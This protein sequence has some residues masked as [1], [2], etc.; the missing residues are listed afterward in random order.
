[1]KK[2][3]AFPFHPRFP[4]PFA[5]VSGCLVLLGASMPAHA[6]YKV[7]L[8]APKSLRELLSAHL[9]LM[10]YRDRDDINADQLRF[11]VETGAEQV[12]EL[13]AT[14]GYFSPTADIR[15]DTQ[16]QP[17]VVSVTVAEGPRT[18]IARAD[19][20]VSGPAREQSPQQA[21][22]VVD[23]WAMKPGAPFRQEDWAAAKD[24]GLRV[25]QER[26]YA[27]AAIASS[28]A[29]IFA[30]RNEAELAVN[31][32]SG[33]PF[34]LGELRI[35]G[36]S[37]YPESII[38][39]VNPLK[40]GEDYDA[41]RLLALQRAL[42][43]T[44]YFSNSV[45]DIDRD[46][47]QAALSPVDVKVTE[48]PTQRIRGGVGYATD[49]GARVEGRYS[50]NNVF[51]RAW[52]FDSQVRVE[53]QRQNATLDLA[54]PPDGTAYVNSVHGSVERTTLEGVE[55]RSRRAGVRR[56][57]S[58]D[59]DDYAYSVE[60]YR[61]ELQQLDGT[62][63]PADILTEPGSHQALVVGYARTHRA[64]D[65]PVFPRSGYIASLEAGVAL[66]GLL[67]DQTFFRTYGKLRRYWPVGERDLVLLRGEVGAVVSKGD[68]SSVPASLLFRA[69]GTESVRGYKYQS[70]GNVR[71]GTVYPT[72][73]LATAGIEYQRWISGAWGGAV[74]YDVGTA[75]DS[76]SEKQLFQGVGI[77]VRYR[78]PVGP[79]NVDLAYGIRNKEFN[80][81][82]SLGVAF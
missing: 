13:A 44:P 49:T 68:N 63:L 21:A 81:H 70:I 26:R 35:S 42:Q 69:G 24:A 36:T 31:Y 76:W 64:V 12:K 37:R 79:V 61:D 23:N 20:E 11:M 27:A 57:R 1:L 73:Y 46:P 10:R 66:K 22:Q 74:F 29:A 53:Q 14:E 62:T 41:G 80:P 18:S 8:D 71:D 32:Q 55:L 40:P 25:L 34:T 82:L 39:N 19:I 17:P 51:G 77:G 28:N 47:A 59:T 67:T 30:D 4:K 2:S 5:V 65:D 54:M 6:V 52:V 75:T 45:V 56:A 78:S 15:L 72:R 9:D 43:R 48:Y 3:K 16:A 33:P 60:Y 38:R 7:E 58:T 50:H